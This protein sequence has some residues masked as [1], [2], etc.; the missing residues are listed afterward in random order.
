M[1]YCFC[2]NHPGR[3]YGAL[4]FVRCQTKHAAHHIAGRGNNLFCCVPKTQTAHRVRWRPSSTFFMLVEPSG[5]LQFRESEKGGPQK[6][7]G[8]TAR[9]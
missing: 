8:P 2:G 6:V 7:S 5:P 4:S 1:F 9:Q 3:S